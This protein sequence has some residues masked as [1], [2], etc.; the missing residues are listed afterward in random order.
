MTK[1]NCIS[2]DTITVIGT[3]GN[4]VVYVPNSFSPDNNRINDV[5]KAEGIDIA[6]FHMSIFD[7][8]GELIFETN[9]LK[10]GWDGYYKGALVQNDVYVWIMDYRTTC[11]ENKLHRRKGIVSVIR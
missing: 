3:V 6:F 4:G 5:F 9:N 8:W 1:G 11:D 7:R 2:T 10:E